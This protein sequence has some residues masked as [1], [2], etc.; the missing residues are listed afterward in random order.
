[1]TS[2]EQPEPDPSPA[3]GAS[4]PP[5]PSPA[6]GASPWPEP[7]PL[8]EPVV[9]PT[10][11]HPDPLDWAQDGYGYTHSDRAAARRS[12]RRTGIAA[13]LV[14]LGVSA[15]GGVM[16]WVWAEVTPR[17]QVIKG[18]KG[19][20]YAD[21]EPEQP[22]A[23]DGWFLLLGLGLGIALALLAWIVLRRY[24][25][26]AMLSGLT[27]GSFL[28]AIFALWVGYKISSAQFTPAA[29]AAPVGAQLNAPIMAHITDLSARDL[30]ADAPAALWGWPPRP[31][32]VVAIQ[33]WT[34]AVVYTVLAGFSIY[35]DLGRRRRPAPD[36]DHLPPPGE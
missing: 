35:P 5:E 4:P 25:G 10:A 8:P 13:L 12:R 31:N 11:D 1:M 3:P 2:P 29:A 7:P 22:I 6:P 32:G 19:F 21:A 24:R 30:N 28:G 17:L 9:G 23:A 26:V 15:L 16:G 14:A 33:A 34:V 36:P 27:V 18:D 20:L